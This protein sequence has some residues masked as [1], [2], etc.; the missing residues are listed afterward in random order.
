[1]KARRSLLIDTIL[2]HYPPINFLVL[3]SSF[4]RAV[5]YV[6]SAPSV[7]TGGSAMSVLKFKL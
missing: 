2:H 4:V 3:F 1:M 7:R 6:S 5:D